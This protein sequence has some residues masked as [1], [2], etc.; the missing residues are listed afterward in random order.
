MS[1][2]QCRENLLAVQVKRFSYFLFS[3]I[4]FPKATFLYWHSPSSPIG[5]TWSHII[6]I[7]KPGLYQAD[8]DL[9]K[10]NRNKA[11]NTRQNPGGN[12]NGYEC[13]EERDYYPY[14]RPSPWID[15]A[16]MT[17][18]MDRCEMYRKESENVKPR[19]FCK[20]RNPFLFVTNF[21]WF[22]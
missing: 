5:F 14:W 22:I 10:N 21:E 11:K 4:H 15:I 18:D 8:Q 20:V 7:F 19:Y 2:D 9:N 6:F 12:R 17:D 16:I 1:D 3:L 13:P